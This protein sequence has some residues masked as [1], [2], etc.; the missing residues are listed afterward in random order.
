MACV[1]TVSSQKAF[2][3]VIT[4][5]ATLTVF[6]APYN[7]GAHDELVIMH[8]VLCALCVNEG[9]ECRQG[10]CASLLHAVLCAWS[11]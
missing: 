7:V 4:T 6:C 9:R 1:R 11:G 8:S 3:F 5:L 10:I 2:A